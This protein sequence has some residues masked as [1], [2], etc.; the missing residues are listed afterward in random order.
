VTS[1]DAAHRSSGGGA[2]TRGWRN[3][4][5]W[6]RSRPFWGG[7]FIVLS[8]L[9]IFGSTQLTLGEIQLK[10]GIQGFQ[11][12]VIPVVL[13][14]CGLLIWFTPQ[15][16][17]FYG[18][19]AAVVALYSLIGVNLGGFLIGMLLG[20]VGGAL[21]VAWTPIE[22]ADPPAEEEQPAEDGSPEAAQAAPDEEYPPGRH[23]ATVDELFTGPLTDVLPRPVNPL[24]E[25]PPGVHRYEDEDSTQRIPAARP[26]EQP[27]PDEPPPDG[28]QERGQGNGTDGPLP[29]RT[30]RLFVITL[31]PLLLT[32]VVLGNLRGTMPARAA[33]AVPYPSACP[34]VTPT[35]TPSGSPSA[36]AKARPAP[37]SSAAGAGSA[38]AAGAGTG[39]KSSQ[40]P[41]ASPSASSTEDGGGNP[42]GDVVSDVGD[43]V[44]DLLGIG[45]DP[46]PSPS[47]T[48]STAPAPS[49]SAAS[50]SAAGPTGSQPP[51]DP[52]PTRSAAEPTDEPTR[53]PSATPKPTSSADCVVVKAQ[54]LDAD[55]VP[56]VQNVPD[57]MQGSK[58]TLEGFSFDGVTELTTGGGDTIRVLQFSMDKAVTD[59]FQLRVPG[60]SG[61]II[62]LTSSALTVQKA[63]ETGQKVK[64]YCT[65]FSGGLVNLGGVP[66]PIPIPLTFTPD[67]PP[68][69]TT[70][71][72]EFVDVP[73]VPQARLNIELVFV[74][75]D[76]LL[77]PDL[78]TSLLS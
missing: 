42:I 1:A 59:D 71:H 8:G 40:K 56:A 16:R 22:A 15:Q 30:P 76:Q 44:G 32:A 27:P 39:T 25:P 34:T 31:I 43:A 23:E 50:P 21:A 58:L 7:L 62:S 17:V 12:Y 57:R 69:L 36:S 51:G 9:Q 49:P 78:H 33:P 75:T 68:P 18:V 61:R 48:P 13:I 63:P 5:R 72:M 65:R 74:D 70:P 77:A 41:A 20:I 53:S 10:V 46:T 19:I 2:L 35:V 73:D 52:D 29:R 55:G 14:L 4:R 54:E 67:I 24:N 38:A 60:P 28:E 3:F 66:L 47:G 64:F 45:A 37:S 26:G 11:S 6:R